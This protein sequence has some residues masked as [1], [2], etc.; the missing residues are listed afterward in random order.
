M[1]ELPLDI[2]VVDDDIEHAETVTAA[3]EKIGAVCVTVH[4]QA[5]ALKWT[6]A[7]Y[8]DVII[9]DLSLEHKL[10]GIDILKSVKQ[11][12]E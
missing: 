10:G 5:D 12:S 3:L 8:F 6:A 9:T 2:L 4:S 11:V 1:D 7:K